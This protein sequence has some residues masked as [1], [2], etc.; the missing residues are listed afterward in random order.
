MKRSKSILKWLLVLSFLFVTINSCNKESSQPSI[1]VT[2]E[3]TDVLPREIILLNTNHDLTADYYDGA[4]G[5]I[6]VRFNCQGKNLS[7]MVPA[8]PKGQTSGK[9]TIDSKEYQFTIN[10]LEEPFIGDV[11]TFF[12]NIDSIN[13]RNLNILYSRMDTL[14]AHGLIDPVKANADK[15]ILQENHAEALSEFANLT[16]AEKEDLAKYMAANK[17]WMDEIDDFLNFYNPLKYKSSKDCEDLLDSA[18]V[19]MEQG[20]NFT[21]IFYSI[22][23]ITCQKVEYGKLKE[24]FQK[25]REYIFPNIY[26]NA[27]NILI[28]QIGRTIENMNLGF[29]ETSE[30]RGT[31]TD[32]IYINWKKSSFTFIN[33]QITPLYAQISFRSVGTEDIGEQDINGIYVDSFQSYDDLLVFFFGLFDKPFYL[34]PTLNPSISEVIAYN[35]NLSI[36]TSSITNSKVFLLTQQYNGDIWE[37]IFATDE[38]TDQDFSFDLVYSDGDTTI[39]KTFDAVVS[40]APVNS[41]YSIEILSGDNQA[42]IM[43][44]PLA[45]LIEVIVKDI[46]GNPFS[47]TIVNFAADNGGSVSQTQVATSADGIASVT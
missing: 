29:Q 17:G 25:A 30:K 33:G 20:N 38:T 23:A 2:P 27:L 28:D 9:L 24:N 11:N 18:K 19:N 10:I 42:G 6:I 21:S 14:I 3:K 40:Q 5:E 7:F 22:S 47:G 8:L 43:G 13:A 35:R 12:L 34:I 1:Q 15:Q 46:T 32:I 36:P 44:Q 26:P 41:A 39:T 16:Q 45:E 4:V 31:P 37:V